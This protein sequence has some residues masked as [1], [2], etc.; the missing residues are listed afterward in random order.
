MDLT[1]PEMWII[2]HIYPEE[3]QKYYEDN[4]LAL[5]Q[6]I[7]TNGRYP[8][9]Y[10]DNGRKYKATHPERLLAIFVQN[11]KSNF[12]NPSVKQLMNYVPDW[13]WPP[14]I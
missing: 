12:G 11:A 5:K 1:E 13:Q 3:F 8:S 4:Y 6:F 2:R 7:V 10:Q 9:E 14:G